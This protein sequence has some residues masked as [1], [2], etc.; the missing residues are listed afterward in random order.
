MKVT[1]N[2]QLFTDLSVDESATV[3]GGCRYHSYRP[4]YYYTP[5]S[6]SYYPSYSYGYG[7]GGYGSSYNR[8]GSSGG[9]VNQTVNVN[10]RY[11][12]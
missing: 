5:R 10:V 8:G 11:D 6:Y 9:S 7:Y 4:S 12:D 3:Q 2:T 1:A